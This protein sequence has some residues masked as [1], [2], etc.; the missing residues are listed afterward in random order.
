MEDYGFHL[1]TEQDLE[2]RRHLVRFEPDPNERI[3]LL[4]EMDDDPRGKRKIESGS[5]AVGLHIAAIMLL[6][7][8]PHIFKPNVIDLNKVGMRHSSPMYLTEAPVEPRPLMKPP[9]VSKRDLEA[10]RAMRPK[11]PALP[12]PEPPPPTPTPN[13]TP[14]PPAPKPPLPNAPVAPVTQTPFGNPNSTLPTTQTPAPTTAPGEI[15]LSEVKPAESPKLPIAPALGVGS[16]DGTLHDLAKKRVE[17]GGGG[18]IVF[19]P[20]TGGRAASSG[21]GQL[22]GAEILSDTQGVDFNPYLQRILFEIRRNWYAVM[23]EI[24]KLGKRGTVKIR[25]EIMRDGTVNKVYLISTSQSDPLDKA[26]F[27]GISASSPFPP[28]PPEYK[29]PMVQLQLSFLYNVPLQQ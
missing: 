12:T 5:L 20:G 7:M 3:S 14:A 26:A 28:L 4:P 22:G 13:P 21:P 8:W 1:Q 9:T 23:P 18:Q 16:L 25:F 2:D 19:N 10:M 17:G 15:R 24:A 11:T 27:A 29:G 6:L